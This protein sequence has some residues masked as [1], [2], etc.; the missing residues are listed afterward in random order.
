MLISFDQLKDLNKNVSENAKR[1][2][3]IMAEEDKARE[4]SRKEK[5]KHEAAKRAG[6]Y[7]M[8]CAQREAAFKKD[9]EMK[10]MH[11]AKEKEKLG[12]A[13]TGPVQKFQNFTWEE[14]ESATCSFSEDCKIGMGGYGTV[15]KCNFH[16]TSAAVKVLCSNE[17]H[18]SKQFQQE[19]IKNHK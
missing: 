12:N 3:E 7:V 10:A 5:E 19:V 4:L 9:A 16:Q 11:D 18:K 6:Q 14:I 8:Q 2:E 17:S 1:L 15:Y 13:L